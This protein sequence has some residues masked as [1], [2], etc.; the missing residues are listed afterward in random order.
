[1]KVHDILKAKV[2]EILLDHSLIL[3]FNGKLLRVINH[4]TRTYEVDDFV[5]LQV[6]RV[7]PLEFKIVEN[8]LAL[9]TI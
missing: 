8:D 2:I 6:A 1:M 3:S 4:T 7:H 5:A 9:H